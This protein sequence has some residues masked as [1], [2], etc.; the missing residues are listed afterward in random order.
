[1]VWSHNWTL[2]FFLSSLNFSIL[3]LIFLL[4]WFENDILK[5][6]DGWYQSFQ[7]III[8]LLLELLGE[9]YCFVFLDLHLKI[10]FTIVMNVVGS[11]SVVHIML[12]VLPVSDFLRKSHK[13]WVSFG[14]FL[15]LFWQNEQA[16]TIWIEDSLPII[17][18]SG[19]IQIIC[20]FLC[21]DD[22]L[23]LVV[24]D[25]LDLLSF[26]L[27]L[28]SSLNIEVISFHWKTMMNF[29]KFSLELELFIA[30]DVVCF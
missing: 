28:F 22:R 4:L 10:S 19:R 12:E 1:M 8:L 14:A 25:L 2:P 20:G 15:E 29:S 11:L 3:L 18:C 13:V 7:F 26:S 24:D 23:V 21:E 27:V 17:H 9:S 5:W 6:D 16:V 30:V